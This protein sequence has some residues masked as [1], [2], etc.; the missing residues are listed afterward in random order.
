MLSTTKL[1]VGLLR[2][3]SIKY[4]L[5]VGEPRQFWDAQ[6]TER[7][8]ARKGSG[9]PDA[10]RRGCHYTKPFDRLP[11]PGMPCFGVWSPARTF[12]VLV[13][14]SVL[15]RLGIRRVTGAGFQ[16][17]THRASICGGRYKW[18]ENHYCVCISRGCNRL[19]STGQL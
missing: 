12:S 2:G 11:E 4:A 5:A 8:P 10:A 1:S 7:Q 19:Y 14:F 17:S 16:A 3:S 9:V 6:I 15:G 13:C 18:D